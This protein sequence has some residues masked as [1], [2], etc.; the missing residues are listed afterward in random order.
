MT[1]PSAL[2][3]GNSLF[4]R[5]V[6]AN[7]AG[8]VF[9]GLLGILT[10]P[11]L[12]AL[13]GVEGYG[14]A[15]LFVLI[16]TW[17]SLLDLGLSQ[18]LMRQT[19]RTRSGATS[20]T[21]FRRLYRAIWVLFVVVGGLTTAIM[22]LSST[23][24]SANWLHPSSTE[25]ETVEACLRLMA[26]A[27][28]LRWLSSLY[29]GIASGFEAFV[30]LGGFNA[31]MAALRYVGVIAVLWLAKPSNP[32]LAFAL[33]QLALGV[34]EF[35]I[36][37]VK[38]RRLTA[39]I[40][41]DAAADEAPGA[42]TFRQRTSLLVSEMR[43]SIFISLS[44]IVWIITTQS[45]RLTL[46]GILPLAEYGMFTLAVTV[47][48]G[49]LMISQ[50]ILNVVNPRLTRAISEGSPTTTRDTY[51]SLTRFVAFAVFPV[52]IAL[53]VVSPQ[54]MRIWTGDE[55]VATY[56]AP[57]VTLYALG[58]TILAICSF[59]YYLQFGQGNLRL[60]MVIVVVQALIIIPLQ[61]ALVITIGAVGAGIAWL[62]MQIVILLL[63]MPFL[64]SR[65]LPGV[66][67]TWFVRGVAI[68]GIVLALPIAVMAVV[69][70]ALHLPDLLTIFCTGATAAIL[71]LAGLLRMRGDTQERGEPGEP[72]TYA[73]TR[74]QIS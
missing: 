41:K 65:R 24:I 6:S 10:L 58:N 74:G 27:G 72:R 73:P 22:L 68:P 28:L 36:L 37:A 15:G 71:G 21:D 48:A 42:G 66:H 63:W 5:N 51:V 44:S 25:V 56:A 30:W 1:R 16:Q 69:T 31:S 26:V 70:Q 4:A 61:V 43:F 57:I 17:F 50:P 60:H 35:S 19:V 2:G 39:S 29:R 52:G 47:A 23:W 54:L 64:H 9:A 38:S 18:A 8:Q 67:S 40:P 62:G 49:V 59:G 11:I 34:L 12:V 33:Y 45:D 3:Q 53:A 13:L 46:S 20:A 7:L 14:L 32:V 55:Y